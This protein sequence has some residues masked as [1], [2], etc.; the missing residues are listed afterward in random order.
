[1]SLNQT[2]STSKNMTS[3]SSIKSNLTTARSRKRKTSLKS[4]KAQD[5]N[6]RRIKESKKS[7]DEGS[8]SGQPSRN[9]SMN[10]VFSE[11][12]EHWSANNNSINSQSTSIK[13]SST[14]PIKEEMSLSSSNLYQSFL[15]YQRDESYKSLLGEKGRTLSSEVCPLPSPAN[16]NNFN[17]HHHVLHHYHYGLMDGSKNKHTSIRDPLSHPYYFMPPNQHSVGELMHHNF[18][19][20]F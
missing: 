11:A 5:V 9:E 15:P 19:E 6:N 17:Y 10:N 3:S 2:D 12:S 14:N 16:I 13:S 1:M 4:P 20:I 8:V 7:P 18:V